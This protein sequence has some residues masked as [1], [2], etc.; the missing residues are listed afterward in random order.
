MYTSADGGAT[1]TEAEQTISGKKVTVT[2]HSETVNRIKVANDTS[3]DAD[4]DNL[5]VYAQVFD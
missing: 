1:W 4:I 5:A 2:V 3:K